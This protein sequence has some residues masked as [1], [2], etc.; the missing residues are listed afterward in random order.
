MVDDIFILDKSGVPYY[1]KC[2][3]GE[4]CKLRP[5][6]AL[7]TGF[8]AALYAYAKESFGAQSEIRSVEFS[9]LQLDFAISDKDN[10]IVVFANPIHDELTLE[11][12]KQLRTTLDIFLEKYKE[13]LIPGFVNH[14]VIHQ[15][16]AELQE[17]GI[18]DRKSKGDIKLK[19]KSEPWWRKILDKVF[20][21]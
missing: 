3:G 2:F 7:Q 19:N 15:F 8:L 12:E 16:E 10:L 4:T 21:N 20:G 18:I 11:R 6:H 1:S 13:Q 9:D 14:E 5:D 17:K